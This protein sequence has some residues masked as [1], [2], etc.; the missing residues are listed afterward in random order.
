MTID[1]V[2]LYTTDLAAVAEF[3]RLC[4]G[5]RI[6][7][8][9][10]SRRRPG[11]VSQFATLPDGVRI[12]LMSAPWIA[13]EIETERKGWDHI[14]LS[15]GS[16]EAVDHAARRATDLGYRVIAPRFTGDGFYE[17]IIV[18]PDGTRTEVTS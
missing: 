9:Y 13:T 5:A 1:H 15:L 16:R 10:E 11:F 14:A 17:A 8:C 18:S 7:D 4:F 6:D 3:W 2:A 12:E